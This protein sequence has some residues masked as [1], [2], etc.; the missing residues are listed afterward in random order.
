MTE[1]RIAST[2]QGDGDAGHQPDP[3]TAP[4]SDPPIRG[5]GTRPL[6]FGTAD[7]PY[8][9]AK[10]RPIA[11]QRLPFERTT[12]VESRPCSRCGGTGGFRSG[13]CYD[14][15]GWSRRPT[16]IGRELLKS[17]AALI[18]ARPALD[19]KGRFDVAPLRT[20]YGRDVRPGM[21]IADI[22]LTPRPRAKRVID[23]QHPDPVVTGTVKITFVDGSRATATALATFAR[24]LTEEEI[25]RADAWMAQ[26]VGRGAV[27][28]P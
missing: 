14:C 10:P 27:V 21:A 22:R 5:R 17:V 13:A 25:E 11:D 19:E 3:A 16:T 18:G 12:L 23:V 7:D 24:E 26:H 20:V 2:S 8:G 1:T 28:A 9:L 4:P 6:A 15:N